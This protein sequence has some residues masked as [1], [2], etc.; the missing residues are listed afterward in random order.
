M[1]WSES[2]FSAWIWR[3]LLVTGSCLVLLGWDGLYFSEEESHPEDG[4]PERQLLPECKSLMKW[5]LFCT[6]GLEW[7]L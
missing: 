7:R 6:C 1:S 3:G 2:Q 4:V 5:G